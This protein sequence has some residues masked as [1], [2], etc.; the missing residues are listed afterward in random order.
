[1]AET[2]ARVGELDLSW[3]NGHDR[4]FVQHFVGLLEGRVS[5]GLGLYV[6]F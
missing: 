4:E 1:V 6:T 2:L 5:G 3:L